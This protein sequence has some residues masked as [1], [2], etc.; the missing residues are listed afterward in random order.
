M[1]DVF[2]GMRTVLLAAATLAALALPVAAVGATPKWL[3][4]AAQAQQQAQAA[5]DQF[6]LPAGDGVWF[7]RDPADISGC[8]GIGKGS[9]GKFGSFRCKV[10]VQTMNKNPFVTATKTL[11]FKVRRQGSG[12]VC[13]SLAGLNAIPAGCLNPSGTRVASVRRF[14]AW[15]AAS[16]WAGGVW[17]ESHPLAQGQQLLIGQGGLRAYGAGY[18]DFSWSI[19]DNPG[20]VV[21]THSIRMILTSA[22]TGPGNCLGS[23][24]PP[25]P[26]VVI[27]QTS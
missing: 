3:W 8:R 4:T 16:H 15:S 14:D 13:A 11:W 25:I 19:R 18:F 26:G 21:E 1:R 23:G 5:S 22:W 2:G 10:R 27:T 12:Q 24:C 20:E 7:V 6:Q 17:K 9:Q